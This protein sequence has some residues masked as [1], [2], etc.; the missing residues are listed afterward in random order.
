MDP[1]FSSQTPS[2][3]SDPHFQTASQLVHFIFLQGLYIQYTPT[4]SPVSP[5]NIL[6]FLSIPVNGIAILGG[7]G[8][9]KSQLLS[10]Q[11]A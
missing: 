10:P 4:S 1:Q 5:P 8:G 3:T 2:L 9:Q 11:P 7:Q 6:L